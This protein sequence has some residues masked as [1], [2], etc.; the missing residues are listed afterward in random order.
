M[1]L[2]IISESAKPI[3]VGGL[4]ASYLGKFKVHQFQ[5]KTKEVDK[6][7]SNQLS[8]EEKQHIRDYINL[9]PKYQSHYSRANNLI[10]VYLNCDMT[11]TR[12]YK[13]FYVSWYRERGIRPVKESAYRK[14]FSTE[15]SIGSKLP[16]EEEVKKLT[17]EF[18]L[19][20]S[21]ATAMQSLMKFE[22]QESKADPTKC[23]KS[24]D[25]QQAMPIPKLTSGPA[26]Y[27]RKI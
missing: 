17:S 21:R 20:K 9:T 24:F 18:N 7:R 4:I 13:E 2:T 6:N 16:N 3:H 12:S 15:F 5:I 8:D 19:H 25:L 22:T 23:V 10:K 11:I 27:Y 1:L 14:V 26:F